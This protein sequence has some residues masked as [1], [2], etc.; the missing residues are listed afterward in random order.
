MW[1]NKLIKIIYRLRSSWKFPFNC[2]HISAHFILTIV[3]LR[4]CSWSSFYIVWKIHSSCSSASASNWGKQTIN[5]KR[6]VIR[7]PIIIIQTSGTD[8]ADGQTN[9]LERIVY[10]V[11]RYCS[12]YSGIIDPFNNTSTM[13]I[14][15][16]TV[17][18]L[19][20][21]ND[22]HLI[23]GFSICIE[24]WSSRSTIIILP[25]LICHP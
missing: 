21:Q 8:R 13:L 2:M 3:S 7:F 10:C 4:S 6:V 20:V 25:H 14:D 19:F 1:R 16:Y 23:S 9:R 17:R 11:Q 15:L 12:T 24:W 22:Q 5:R 18:C